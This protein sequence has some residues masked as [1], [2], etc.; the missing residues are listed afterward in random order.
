MVIPLATARRVGVSSVEGPAI[1]K[2]VDI[3]GGALA[4]P[5][6]AQDAEEFSAVEEDAS[7]AMRPQA[8]HLRI[9]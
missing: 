1:S 2:G 9:V 3:A 8:A 6:G 5:T 7:A 4:G